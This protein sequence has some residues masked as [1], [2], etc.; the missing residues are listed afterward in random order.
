MGYYK[1]SLY[2]KKKNFKH[3][4]NVNKYKHNIINCSSRERTII[5]RGVGCPNTSCAL[6]TLGSKIFE[7]IARCVGNSPNSTVAGYAE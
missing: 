3:R 1:V 4:W 5:I 7:K 2:K 6:F